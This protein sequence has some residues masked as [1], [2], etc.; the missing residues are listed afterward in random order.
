[1]KKHNKL[2]TIWWTLFIAGVL[3]ASASQKVIYNI[4]YKRA[5]DKAYKSVYDSV[6]R[7]TYDRATEG[8][9]TVVLVPHHSCYAEGE[10]FL[11]NFGALNVIKK[12]EEKA[13]KTATEAVETI[14]SEKAQTTAD[15]TLDAGAFMAIAGLV[16]LLA[17]KK[18]K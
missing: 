10:P 8:K 15:R 14:A 2:N 17:R 18:S 12:A 5:Y 1:M 9:D 13:T 16:A 3:S 11:V 6:Y 4:A 7:A